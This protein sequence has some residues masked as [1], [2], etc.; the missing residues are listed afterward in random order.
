MAPNNTCGGV[1]GVRRSLPLQQ[2]NNDDNHEDKNEESDGEADVQREVRGLNP[3]G[4]RLRRS[5]G[6][7]YDR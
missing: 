7:D 4:L 1:A 2:T 3:A 6:V 5:L